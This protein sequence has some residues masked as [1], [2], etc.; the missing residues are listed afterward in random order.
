MALYEFLQSKSFFGADQMFIVGHGSN[1]PVYSTATD[2]GRR[3][4][5]RIELVIYPETIK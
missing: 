4:N 5:N 1:H 2:S 3:A